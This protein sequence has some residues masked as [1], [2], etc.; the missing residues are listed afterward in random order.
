MR[1]PKALKKGDYIG[2][3]A[4]S[5]GIIEELKI[6]RLENAEKNLREKG[7]NYIETSNVRKEEKGRSSSAKERAKQ[8]MDLWNNEKVGAI[9][10]ATGGDFMSEILDEL[11]FEEI[12]KYILQGNKVNECIRFFL[13]YS[14]WES[15]QLHSEIKENTWLVS[16]E[17]NSYLMRNDTKDM[18]KEALEKLGSKYETWSRFP[19]VPTLN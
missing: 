18:W 15:N 4:P 5:A 6:K 11:D 14:G 12:K 19:Q 7:F 10:S 1:Y 8:F 2:V 9:I 3:T 16:K 13:G 17:E